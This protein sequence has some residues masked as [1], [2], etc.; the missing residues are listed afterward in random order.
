[1][2][3][4]RKSLKI[5]ENNS[6]LVRVLLSS[7]I[8]IIK[9]ANWLQSRGQA[10]ISR[11]SRSLIPERPTDLAPFIDDLKKIAPLVR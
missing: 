3:S 2:S 10:K 7:I 5:F 1:M 11:L 6:A 9:D 8:S 4:N